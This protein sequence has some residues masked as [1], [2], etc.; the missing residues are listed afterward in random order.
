[1]NVLA[2]ARTELGTFGRS[3]DFRPMDV[4]T[5]NFAQYLTWLSPKLLEVAYVKSLY[6][7]LSQL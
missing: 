5:N 4:Q 1:M 7:V 6:K 2:Y 3:H